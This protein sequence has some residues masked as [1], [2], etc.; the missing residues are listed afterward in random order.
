[1]IAQPFSVIGDDRNDGP[2]VSSLLVQSAKDAADLSV[3]VSHLRRVEEVLEP[4]ELLDGVWN[5][6]CGAELGLRGEGVVGRN[7]SVVVL[8]RRSRFGVVPS[9]WP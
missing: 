4:A 3:L 1:V 7:Q 5:L 6:R 2:A 9:G 8:A